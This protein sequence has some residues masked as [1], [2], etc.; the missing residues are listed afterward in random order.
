MSDEADATAEFEDAEFEDAGY[1]NNMV[2]LLREQKDGVVAALVAALF[3]P[4][5]ILNFFGGVV[6]GIWLAIL[7]EWWAIGYGIVGLLGA[8]F[9]L[10]IA[11][12][13]SILLIAPAS[14]FFDKSHP[15]LASP[16]LLLGLTYVYALISAWCMFIFYT[17]MFRATENSF[18]PLLIWSYGVAHVPL[19][20]MAGKEEGVGGSHTTLFAAVAY[21]VMSLCYVFADTTL[22]DLAE[23]FIG[24]M[25]VGLLIHI[26]IGFV[27]MRA[28]ARA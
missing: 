25:I 3:I 2:S 19:F 20:Y 23:I 11:L 22:L 14:Y 1:L 18:W 24:I 13:P 17:F 16:F 6:A 4:F 9:V 21:V 26:G 8:H 12:M 10:A 28:N 5:I 27:A 15:I 7:G